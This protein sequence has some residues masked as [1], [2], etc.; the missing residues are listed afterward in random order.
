MR[1]NKSVEMQ[2][3]PVL[4]MVPAQRAM[5]LS[6]EGQASFPRSFVTAAQFIPS[7]EP[8]LAALIFRAASCEWVGATRSWQQYLASFSARR[9]GV[10]F[11]AVL[12]VAVVVCCVVVVRVE[13]VTAGCVVLVRVEVVTAACVV[14]VL[15]RVE[16]GEDEAAL[17]LVVAVE[18][19]VT[20]VEEDGVTLV[21]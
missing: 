21:E 16:V 15:V 9:E 7:I 10:L 13:V 12:V 19:V 17:V 6:V 8:A 4:P 5:A 1:V 18:L 11:P 2:S 3:T 14:L 20:R